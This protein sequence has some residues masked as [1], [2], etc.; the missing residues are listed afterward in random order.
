MNEEFTPYDV[1]ND[2]FILNTESVDYKNLMIRL[3]DISETISL[4]EKK[5]LDKL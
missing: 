3:K 2:E 4:L 1:E 5:Y